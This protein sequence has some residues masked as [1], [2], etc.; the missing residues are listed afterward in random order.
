MTPD[1]RAAVELSRIARQPVR[2]VLSRREELTATGNRPGS[3]TD[4]DLVVGDD[5]DLEAMLID[6][7]SISGVAINSPYALLGTLVYGRSPRLARDRD[8]ITNAP[9]GTPFRGPGGPTY[10][11]ALEQSVDQAAHQLGRDP[12]DLRRGWWAAWSTLCSSAHAYV[13]PPGPRNGVPGGAFVMM[14]RSRARRGLRPSTSVP[15][16]A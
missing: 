3:R 14:S 10:A 11:W 2:V 6:A 16:K 1:M 5:G 13:G 8:I 9:P 15:S 12:I 4:V 7:H